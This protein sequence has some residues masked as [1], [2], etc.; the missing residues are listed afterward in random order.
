[1]TTQQT[2]R[3]WLNTRVLDRW[4]MGGR[5]YQLN[6]ISGDHAN[7]EYRV[8]EDLRVAV[9]APVDFAVGLLHA[10]LSA[11]TF[12]GVL[13]FIGGSLTIPGT[14][15]TIPGFLVAARWSRSAAASS[16]SP[17]TRT[18]RK[19]SIDTGSRVCASTARASR[20]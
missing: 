7:P 19:R 2:W 13:W 17:R 18:K 1:L 9:E 12:I 10:V 20:S 15:V 6:F 14:S 11:L 8:A 3:R 4:I 16:S 5:Y